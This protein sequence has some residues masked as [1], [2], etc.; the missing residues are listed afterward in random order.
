MDFPVFHLDFL[1]NRFLIAI[2]A[3]LHVLINHPLAV[4]GLPLI[5]LLEWWGSKKKSQDEMSQW[6]HLAYRI[7]FVFFIITTT[8]GAMTGV[9]IWLSA[10]LINPYAIGSLIRVFFWA[11][12]VEWIVFVTEVCLI[13]AYFL[14]WKKLL[15]DKAKHIRL[16][17]I[18]SVASWITMSIIVAILGFMMDPGNW[19]TDRSLING[20]LNPLYL[21]QLAFRTPLAMVMGGAVGLGFV[22]LFA[23]HQRSLRLEASALIS[24]WMIF[25]LPFLAVGGYW[26]YHRLP[27]TMIGN[28]A[29]AN[30]TQEFANWYHILLVTI[31]AGVVSAF[32]VAIYGSLG[33]FKIPALVSVVPSLILMGLLAHFERV[34]EFI[35]KPYAIGGY[36]YSN[37]FREEDYPLFKKDGILK[38]ATYSSVKTITDQNKILAGKEVFMLACTR[39]HTLNGINSIRTNITAMYGPGPW[40]KDQ[41]SNYIGVMHSTRRYMPPFPGSPQEL[42]ALAAYLVYFGTYGDQ[43]P[44]AQ[45]IGTKLAQ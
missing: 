7:L 2:I 6:D 37:G 26:Y 3:V 12:F 1:N 17:I 33:R 23:R 11:W 5:T 9:G 44:G 18:L 45:S 21:P 32:A 39:C 35:R 15:I 10:S 13:L 8:L 41:L 38:H 22:N 34:R 31:V 28:L 19:R 16:G 27:S 42:D 30:T 40:S 20:I 25:W 36:L 29:V 14:T 24:R 43:L 4:G